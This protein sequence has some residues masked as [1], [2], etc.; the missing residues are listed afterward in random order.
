MVA[1]N[2]LRHDAPFYVNGTS[3]RIDLPAPLATGQSAVLELEWAY[4]SPR[5]AATP[6]AMRETR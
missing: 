4:G 3:M 6:S 1:A 5:S 2:G